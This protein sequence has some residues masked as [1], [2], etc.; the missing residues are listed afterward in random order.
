MILVLGNKKLEIA[1]G[2]LFVDALQ[3]PTGVVWSNYYESSPDVGS[4]K[5][6]ALRKR[7]S[8]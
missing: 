1:E 4:C 8:S 2:G 6:T 3:A 7:Y 5:A